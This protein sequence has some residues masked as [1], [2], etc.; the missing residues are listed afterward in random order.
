[1]VKD[2]EAEAIDMKKIADEY[3][4]IESGENIEKHID[5]GKLLQKF[6]K[7]LKEIFNEFRTYVRKNYKNV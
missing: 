4:P 3:E 5:E 6:S 2:I 7:D 1:M